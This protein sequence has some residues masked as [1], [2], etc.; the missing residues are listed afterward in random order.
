MELVIRV[1]TADGE[2]TVRTT[3][4]SIVQLERAYKITASDLVR[5]VSIEQLGYLAWEA[6][7]AAGHNP[8]AKLDDFLRS[9]TELA[10]VEGDADADPSDGGQ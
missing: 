5:G 6:S 1:V 3:L 4:F 2:Y 10:V 7:K 9:L 8:P